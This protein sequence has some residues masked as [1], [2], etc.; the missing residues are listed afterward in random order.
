MKHII[1]DI[2]SVLIGYRWQDMLMV[3]HGMPEESAWKIGRTVFNSPYWSQYDAGLIT[4]A[5][6]VE[7]AIKDI[8]ELAEDVKWFFEHAELMRVKRPLIWEEMKLLR[9][10]GYKMYLLSNYSGELLNIHLKDTGIEELVDGEVISY[11][12]HHVKPE[13]EIYQYLLDKYDLKAEDCLFFDD[14]EDNVEAARKLGF[15]G[16]VVTSEEQLLEELQKL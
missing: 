2:G 3:D 8:P 10:K 9:K 7:Y 14:R 4:T 1:F 6:M 16:I 13:P 15:S 11:Q 12:I 5:E